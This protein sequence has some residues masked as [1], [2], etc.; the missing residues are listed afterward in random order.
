MQ[1]SR[2]WTDTGLPSNKAD[3]SM[4]DSSVGTPNTSALADTNIT[5]P[6]LATDTC[7]SQQP[8]SS[9]NAIVSEQSLDKLVHVCSDST[10]ENFIMLKRWYS[11]RTCE[12]VF[13]T[14]IPVLYKGHNGAH[15]HSSVECYFRTGITAH[16][17]LRFYWKG[18]QSKI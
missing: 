3:S 13:A 17:S 4:Q 15:H 8:N 5:S 7:S 6:S 10:S 16:N 14:R 12:H 11:T 9:D 18:I 2:V 1:D